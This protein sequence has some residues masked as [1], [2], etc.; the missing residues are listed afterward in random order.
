[1]TKLRFVP[2]FLQFA[3]YNFQLKLLFKTIKNK[4]EYQSYT[5]VLFFISCKCRLFKPDL[6]PYY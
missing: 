2:P 1:M 6:Q 5:L 4:K 3:D